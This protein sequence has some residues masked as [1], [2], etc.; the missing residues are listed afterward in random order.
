MANDSSTGGYLLP[1]VTGESLSGDNLRNLLQ[2]FVVGLTGLSGNVV[3]PRWQ[4]EPVNVPDRAITWVSLGLSNRNPNSFPSIV[5]HPDGEGF[6]QLIS[7]Q[8]L[9]LTLTFYGP[10]ADYYCG[11]FRDGVFVE[12]NREILI[13]NSIEVVDIGNQINTAELIKNI[14]TSRYD[15]SISL[16][17]KI[18]RKY[19]ILNVL[20]PSFT[21]DN[22][23]YLE[24]T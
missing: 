9:E 7:H 14:Y 11:R 6:D 1:E 17:Q 5:H 10:Q 2:E 20:E 19:P 21:I 24:I 13:L 4:P 15:I 12:Q 23:V 18:I 8:E 16:R 22:E 3:I